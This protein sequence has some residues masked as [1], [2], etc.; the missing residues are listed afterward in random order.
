MRSLIAAILLLPVSIYFL[1]VIRFAVNVPQLDDFHA[2]LASTQLIREAPTIKEA[3]G[4]SIALHNEHRIGYTRWVSLVAYACGPINFRSIIL[5]GNL[6]LLG[7]LGLFYRSFQSTALP[8]FYFLPVPFLL[9]QLQYFENTF[10]AMAALQ[11]LGVWCWAGWSLWWLISPDLTG[12]SDQPGRGWIRFAGSL[13][14]ALLATFT[15]GNGLFVWPLGLVL[16]VM[17]RKR[18]Q[19]IGWTLA[20]G[21]VANTYFQDFVGNMHHRQNR[22]WEVIQAGF[23]YI[24]ALI[25]FPT[26]LP[27]AIN[28]PIV[29][30]GVGIV[31][32]TFV[33]VRSL[34][35]LRKAW[36]D[37][38]SV[39]SN[40]AEAFN[41]AYFGFVVL[42]AGAISLHRPPIL[43][44]CVPRY[45]IATALA[46]ILVY[47]LAL[48]VLEN[49]RWRRLFASVGLVGSVVFCGLTYV[50]NT[51]V[52]KT[53]RAALIKDVHDFRSVGRVSNPMYQREGYSPEA[54]W[55]KAIRSGLYEL[56]NDF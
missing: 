33:A 41:L 13:S 38:R 1:W 35:W 29:P 36:K 28:G 26:S 15:S 40:P 5:W 24:G 56:P 16:L 20:F 54:E 3:F 10:F 31:L 18:R 44:I 30:M 12:V 45:R 22:L 52:I 19:L 50:K 34:L 7:I 11:N 6:A 39:G 17:Q 43:A 48:P 14:M 49:V 46:F 51:P 8:L 4:W 55:Q 23:G 21:W 27:A 42:T 9:F 25:G 2:I 53:Q 47:V 37:S 32:C